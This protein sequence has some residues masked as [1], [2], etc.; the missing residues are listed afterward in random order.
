MSKESISVG[1]DIGST[2]VVT[3]VGKFDSGI[4]DIIGIGQALNQGM[5]KGVIV[6][7]EETVSAISA[8]L[9]EAE[10]MAGIALKNAVVGIDG[11]HIESTFSKGVIAV[12]RSDGE[13]S[14]QDVDR[15]IQAARAIPNR[16]NREIL[17]S[18]P[19]NFIID[20][21]DE[22]KDPLGMSAIRLE[23]DTQ[24]ISTST[25]AIKNLE[26]CVEQSG[27][28]PIETIFSPLATAKV[29]LSKR[30]MEIGVILI[31]IGSSSTSYA[32]FE[33]GD[34][35]HCGVIPIGSAHITND[36]AIGLRTSIEIAEVLK[37]KYGFALPD[38]VSEK[39]E[40]NLKNIDKR[41]EGVVSIKYI[42]E[43]IEARL[44][45]ILLIIRQ[46]LEKIER[47]G[48][49]PAGIIL[50]GGGCKLEGIVELSKE[51]LRLP[52][53]IGTPLVEV[54]GLVDKVDDPVY[55]T[56]VGLMLWGKDKTTPAFQLDGNAVSGILDKAK[57]FLKQLMP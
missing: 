15:V 42:S 47:D 56:S 55:A 30:Q 45:E 18:I 2:K 53:Q 25:N 17:H 10:R 27:I 4:I 21:Q 8:S 44:K 32:V 51:T 12:S 46:H 7:V 19:I 41:E 34:L 6:D 16:P 20:G 48:T 14:D 9:E 29:L 38:K 3:C 52:A 57:G 1:L 5:R 24:I 33:E 11:P 36:I 54:N 37:I 49:L 39:D 23:V 28:S 43:I 40:V 22:V 31:D 35:I 50:T 13:I 26:R